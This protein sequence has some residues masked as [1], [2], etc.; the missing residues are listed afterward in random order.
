MTLSSYEGWEGTH[1]AVLTPDPKPIVDLDPIDEFSAP[2]APVEEK[3]AFSMV[4]DAIRRLKNRRSD[5]K[6]QIRNLQSYPKDDS[7]YPDGTTLIWH[8]YDNPWG[9]DR[10]FAAVK[11]EGRWYIAGEFHAHRWDEM[12]TSR[13]VAY[14]SSEVEVVLPPE[15]K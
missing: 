14:D 2:G 8:D 3:E 10:H 1:T 5:I 13:L 7:L 12:L 6:E 4:D 15:E 9:A 11:E